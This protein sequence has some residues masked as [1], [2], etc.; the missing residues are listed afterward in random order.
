MALLPKEPVLY[1]D[2]AINILLLFIPFKISTTWCNKHIVF[3]S[4]H[5]REDFLNI[6]DYFLN[7]LIDFREDL[8]E[9]S[10]G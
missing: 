6:V 9:A 8:L 5:F 2:F 3:I 1:I 10:K 4:I 7:I